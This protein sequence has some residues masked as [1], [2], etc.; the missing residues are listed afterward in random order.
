VAAKEQDRLDESAGLMRRS[1]DIITTAEGADSPTLAT[2]WANLG[3][4]LGA[5]GKGEESLAAYQKA[6]AVRE[7]VLP[8]DHPD[9][10]SA[11][12]NVGI[13][14]QENLGRPADAVPYFVRA[15]DMLKGKL[16]PDHPTL[17]FALHGHGSARLD[18][19]QA[20]AAVPDLEDAYR[21]RSGKDIDPRLRA[22]TGYML[23][24]ALWAA[25]RPGTPARARAVDVARATRQAFGELGYDADPWLDAHGR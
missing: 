6:L 12:M 24:K 2:S 16:G 13:A 20:A 5:M 19:G 10:A 9:L 7:K 14:L 25:S 8:P 11:I 17:A 4:V 18:L 15:R 22:D 21:I 3:V 1:I 23:A